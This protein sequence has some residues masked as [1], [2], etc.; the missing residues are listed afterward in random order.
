[1]SLSGDGG[2]EHQDPES[3]H[4]QTVLS[5]FLTAL[6]PGRQVRA[7]AGRPGQWVNHYP[8]KLPLAEATTARPVTM[9]LT[10]K[11]RRWGGGYRFLFVVLDLDVKRGG[12]AQVESD[13]TELTKLL[14]AHGIRSVP[15][16]SGPGGGIHLWAACPDGLLP[17]EVRRIADAAAVLFPTL[18][19]VPLTNEGSGSVRPPGAAHRD[20]G[21]ARLTEHTVGQAVTVLRDGSPPA[22][23]EALRTTL[24]AMA[25]APALLGAARARAAGPGT[26]ERVRAGGRVVPHAVTDR[27]PVVRPLTTDEDGRVRLRRPWRP[28]SARAVTALQRRPAAESGAHSRAVH[29]HVRTM[30][31]S[32]WSYHQM[33]EHA[34]DPD[35]TPAL[36]WLRTASTSTGGRKKLTAAEADRRAERV[37]WLAVQ[38]AARLPRRPADHGHPADPD[39]SPGARAAAD[40]LARVEAADPEH[41]S[42]PSGSADRNALRAVAYLMLRSG[43]ADVTA[44]VRRMAVLM[45]RSKST[46]ALSLGRVIAD[47]WLTVTQDA[48]LTGKTGRR[49]TL[50]HAHD[51]TDDPHHMCAVYNEAP[52]HHGSDGSSSRNAAPP[53]PPGALAALGGLAR[54]IS[55]Q[56]SGI[57]QGIGH[58]A[59]RTLEALVGGVRVEEVH[60]VTGYSRRTSR[61]HVRVLVGLGLVTLRGAGDGSW[62]GTVAVRTGRSLYEAAAELGT[63]TRPAE[64]AMA[65]IVDRFRFHWW[66]REVRWCSLPLPDKR[67]RG[68]RAGPDQLPLAGA[69]PH[70]RAYP[71]DADHQADHGR[72]WDLEALRVDA[73]AIAAAA[74]V[75]ARV[76]HV[77]DTAALWPEPEDQRAATA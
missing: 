11:R 63:A 77:V 69:D 75:M 60:Q 48:S 53:S 32:G 73:A 3:A 74:D 29:T 71:R 43:S 27:G 72:A 57:W 5:A 1:M 49:V 18:D 17:S 67:R 51:C 23:W 65:G 55:E 10:A 41:W 36:E 37:W 16:R 26:A 62:R 39:L 9:Y 6:S 45:G 22:A 24:E 40:L 13:A 25:G 66:L 54:V 61:R 20:G 28:L 46:A 56:Q 47:G 4:A 58:P 68:R 31:L 12:V 42:R 52:G 2:P 64:R 35:L 44:D 76:G 33:R 50:A 21:Y 8:V 14:A 15:V 38:D 59:G 34:A 7:A 19:I 70:G 30:A